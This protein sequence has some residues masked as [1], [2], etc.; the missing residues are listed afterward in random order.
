[1]EEYGI[2]ETLMTPSLL[3]TVLDV[4]GPDLADHLSSL[5]VLWLNGEVVTRTLARRALSLLPETRLLNVYSC[6][7]THEV[8]TCDLRELSESPHSTYCPVGR[9][10]DPA[11]LYILDEYLREVPEGETGELFVGG[12]CLA[13]GYVNL[14]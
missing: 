2:S 7:E 6:S 12:D 11:R 10:M 4:S 1:M 5:R 14:P 9:P 13:R 8:A 3:E